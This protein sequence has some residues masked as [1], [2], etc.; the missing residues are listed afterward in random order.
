MTQ[1]YRKKTRPET[2][3]TNSNSEFLYNAKIY[4]FNHYFWLTEPYILYNISW[5]SEL[6]FFFLF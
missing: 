5:I 1:K 4:L 6:Y 3:H 2:I